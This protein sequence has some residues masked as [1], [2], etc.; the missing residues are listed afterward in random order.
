VGS[1]IPAIKVVNNQYVRI[2]LPIK[3][4]GLSDRCK[5]TL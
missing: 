3:K 5:R 4:E 2:A 1:D